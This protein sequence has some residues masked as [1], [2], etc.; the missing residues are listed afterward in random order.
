VHPEHLLVSLA[1]VEDCIAARILGDHGVT[2]SALRESLPSLR[3]GLMSPLG[4]GGPPM[5]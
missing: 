4:R 3:A 1:A 2:V 5:T